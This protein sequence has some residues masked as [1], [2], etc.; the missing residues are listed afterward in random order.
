M[1]V[2][3][4][5]MIFEDI[6]IGYKHKIYNYEIDNDDVVTNE[7]KSRMNENQKKLREYKIKDWRA[8]VFLRMC[9]Y[10]SIF[11]WSNISAIMHAIA[12]KEAFEKVNIVMMY[13]DLDRNGSLDE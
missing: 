11:N 12:S 3:T 5:H 13:S 6:K 9:D 2:C 8:E 10:D 7:Q 4:N 1:D